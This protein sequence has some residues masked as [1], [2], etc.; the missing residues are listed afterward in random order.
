MLRTNM[1]HDYCAK[2]TVPHPPNTRIW[3]LCVCAK[4]RERRRARNED[5]KNTR[6]HNR[7]LCKYRMHGKLVV[8]LFDFFVRFTFNLHLIIFR[9]KKAAAGNGNRRIGWRWRRWR[10]GTVALNALQCRTFNKY[11]FDKQ[12]RRIPLSNTVRHYCKQSLNIFHGEIGKYNIISIRWKG[13]YAPVFVLTDRT[14]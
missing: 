3:S 10:Y 11:M 7:N 6:T 14:Q 8:S 13:D 9:A 2:I 12:Q 4:E 5:R 1:H